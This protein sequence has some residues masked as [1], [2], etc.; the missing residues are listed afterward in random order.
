MKR[1]YLTISMLLI[2][3]LIIATTCTAQ[4]SLPK[5]ET[6]YAKA[7]GDLADGISNEKWF[8]HSN[9]SYCIIYKNTPVGIKHAFEKYDGL[10]IEYAMSDCDDKS[11]ISTL[12]LNDDKTYD[13]G[14]L[15]I[16]ITQES[17]E[18]VINCTSSNSKKIGL[19]S[20]GVS[21]GFLTLMFF[22]SEQ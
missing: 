21:G 16:T 12:A 20:S 4:N 6:T 9:G 18:I 13:Y 1:I 10:K 17:S 22:V 5:I 8:L 19:Y 14:M 2:M 15:S 3:S 11:M 7:L